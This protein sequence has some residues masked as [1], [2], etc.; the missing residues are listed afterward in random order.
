MTRAVYARMTMISIRILPFFVIAVVSLAQTPESAV[1]LAGTQLRTLTSAKIGQRYELLISLPAG[2]EKSGESYPVLYVLDGWHFPLMTFMQENN[3]YSKRMRPVIIVN[4][5][6]GG[7]D[8]MALRARDF[9]PTKTPQ[10]PN[11]G[12]AAVF[13]DFLEHELIPFVDRTWRTIPTDRGLL[14]HSFGGVFAHYR[15]ESIIAMGKTETRG[16]RPSPHHLSR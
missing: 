5:S 8:Y 1:R 9:T 10:Y 3:V 11:S 14:G 2:Y 4:V 13:L 16:P 15:R 7:G 12:G 6:H